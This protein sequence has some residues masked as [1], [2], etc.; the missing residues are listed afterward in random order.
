V[1]GEPRAQGVLADL[2]RDKHGYP[3]VSVPS[4]GTRITV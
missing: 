3:D 2:L 4:P 1:H